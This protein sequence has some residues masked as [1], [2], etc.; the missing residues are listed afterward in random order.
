M[1]SETLGIKQIEQILSRELSDWLRWGR[2]KD[3]LPVSYGSLLG[4]LYVP[5]RG[6]LEATLYKPAPINLLEV[7]EF[8]KIV[9]GL[10]KKH[11]QAFVMHHLGRAHVRGRILEKK[12]GGAEIARHLG[13]HRSR[14]YVLL[15][16]A[17]RMI[18]WRWKK[19]QQIKADK[20]D[21]EGVDTL[22]D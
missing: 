1:E 22:A 2:G 3:Y 20:K 6:D 4:K 12:M 7:L 21:L 16:Q 14:Y 18:Y 19:Q 5:K 9:I 15:N 11:K 13:V 10:P 17:Y 8:E